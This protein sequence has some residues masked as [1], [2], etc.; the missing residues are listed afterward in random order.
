MTIL[1]KQP[2]DIEDIQSLVR[3]NDSPPRGTV[4]VTL[5]SPYE[6]LYPANDPAM[7]LYTGLE[8]PNDPR[9]KH[10]VNTSWPGRAWPG[11]SGIQTYKDVIGINIHSESMASKIMKDGPPYNGPIV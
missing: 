10:Q 6:K 7:A 8:V 4:G 3:V 11:A 5:W 2:I 1:V 9:S